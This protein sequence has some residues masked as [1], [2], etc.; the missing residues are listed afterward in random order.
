VTKTLHIAPGDSAGGS[1][2]QAL[3]DV[4][5]DDEVLRFR[6]DLSCGPI[7]P[8]NPSTRAQWWSRFHDASEVEI[9]LCSF[10]QRA[11]QTDDRI[12]VWFGRH[13]ASELAFLLAWAHRLGDRSYFVIDVTGRELSFRQRDGSL[14]T[15]R[16]QS[17]SIIPPE[18]LASLLGSER[19]FTACEREEN[20]ESWSRLRR[21]NAPFRIVTAAGLTSAPVDYFDPL[22]LQRAAPEWRTVARVVGYTLGYNSE[23]YIQVGD[24][25]L[26][27]RVVALV[28]EGKLLAEGDPWEM[29]CRVRLPD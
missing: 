15:K 9:S 17:V 28:G 29:R 4:G 14:T 3:R 7:D 10:W 8:D 20:Q 19:P 2:L 11:M 18:P 1:L 22:L 21:E 24:L 27:S 5:S 6:D 12:V 25:M 26:Q 23:P 16:A 13:A